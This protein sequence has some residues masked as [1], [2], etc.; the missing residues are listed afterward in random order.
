MRGQRQEDERAFDA[1]SPSSP[2]TRVGA[3]GS[4]VPSSRSVPD[5]EELSLA[6]TVKNKLQ[7]VTV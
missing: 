2:Q 4:C 7:F 5:K 1:A 3:G 6:Q